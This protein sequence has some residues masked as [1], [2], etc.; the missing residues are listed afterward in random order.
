N[1]FD[2]HPQLDLTFSNRVTLTIDWDWFWRESAHDAI[3]GPAVNVVVPDS[4][5]DA[6]VVGDQIELSAEWRINRHVT[7]TG[8][9]AHFFAKDFLE[10]ATPGEDINYFTAWVTF[11]F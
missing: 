11:K 9:Y 7:F 5:S 3:Y 2:L 6:R 10:E 1:H 4:G 8:D